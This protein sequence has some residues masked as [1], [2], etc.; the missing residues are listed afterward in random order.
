M[1]VFVTVLDRY[2]HIKA[3]GNT[4]VGAAGTV[5][6]INVGIDVEVRKAHN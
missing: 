2:P 6:V 4:T 1:V 3:G 5:P